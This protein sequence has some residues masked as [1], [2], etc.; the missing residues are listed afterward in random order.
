MT[1]N[2]ATNT[3]STDVEP[4]TSPTTPITADEKPTPDVTTNQAKTAQKA[5]EKTDA[6]IRS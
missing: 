1:D 6:Y 5:A 4:F 3:V 2:A